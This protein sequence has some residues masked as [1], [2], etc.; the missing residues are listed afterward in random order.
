[1]K[2]ILL[3]VLVTFGS[4][5]LFIQSVILFTEGNKLPS[6][7]SQ[8]TSNFKLDLPAKLKK[9][10]GTLNNI[11][12]FETGIKN[13]VTARDLNFTSLPHN[14]AKISGL[15]LFDNPYITLESFSPFNTYNWRWRLAE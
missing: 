2:K 13:S 3:T 5:Q 15:Q 8:T 10:T 6:H 1:M 11:I 12:K 7:R 14:I 9:P 4:A